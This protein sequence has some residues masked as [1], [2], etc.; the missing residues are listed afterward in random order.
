[1]FK[2][3]PLET[4]INTGFLKNSATW[5]VAKLFPRLFRLSAKTMLSE[6]AQPDFFGQNY[7]DNILTLM[8][9]NVKVNVKVLDTDMD[10]DF[11]NDSDTGY[12]TGTDNVT[13]NGTGTVTMGRDSGTA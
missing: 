4:R 1:M 2:E 3:H 11:E 9:F 6:Y 8:K 10:T 13:G 5:V 12:V 7:T